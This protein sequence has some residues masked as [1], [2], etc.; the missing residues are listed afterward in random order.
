MG[1]RQ[2]STN[3]IQALRWGLV[4][5]DG[6]CEFTLGFLDEN[7]D[8]ITFTWRASRDIE[9]QQ[10]HF[11]N[12]LQAAL[13]YVMPPVIERID[14]QLQAGKT[15]YI[16]P[17]RLTQQGILFERQGWF[18]SKQCTVPWERVKV[19]LQN[20]EVIV[21]DRSTP[22]D[23]IGMPM[24]NTQNAPVLHFLASRATESP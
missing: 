2:V 24:R 12:L 15:V 4:I 17:C 14:T 9:K 20:G 18:S 22:K 21:C 7:A 16:G 23:K 8:E 11:N 13:A 5:Q 1:A 10:E 6:V 3:K 19:E